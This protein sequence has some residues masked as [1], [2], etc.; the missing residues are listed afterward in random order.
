MPKIIGGGYYPDST[1]RTEGGYGC[2]LT[3][4]REEVG[5]DLTPIGGEVN[6]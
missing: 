3:L 2:G 4:G 1:I 5:G 6:G